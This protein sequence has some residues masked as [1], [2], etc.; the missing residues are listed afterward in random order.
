MFNLK[1]DVTFGCIKLDF[2]LKWQV[3]QLEAVWVSLYVWH[4]AYG[5]WL[6]LCVVLD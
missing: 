5:V 6:S 4:L 2:K 1:G 3:H